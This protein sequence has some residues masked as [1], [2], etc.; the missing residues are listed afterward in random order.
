MKVL[1]VFLTVLNIALAENNHGI[2]EL[3][4]LDTKS[5]KECIQK[6]LEKEP[7]NIRCI[8]KL[9]NLYLRQGKVEKGFS[10]IGRAY[11]INPEAVKKSPISSILPFALKIDALKKKA[12]KNNDFKAWNEIGNNFYKMGIYNDAIL[13]YKNSLAINPK[14]EEINVKMALSYKKIG[15]VHD[16]LSELKKVLKMNT[17]NF[18]ANYF[19]GKILRYSLDDSVSSKKYFSKARRILEANKKV[20]SPKEYPNFL[21]DIIYELS[22]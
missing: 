8:I 7:E 14:Q 3:D 18:Y 20:V 17:N 15:H 1:L 19:A 11:K 9:A 4:T 16:A 13:A 5:A 6:V 22:I 2:C 12:K 10:L 21:N